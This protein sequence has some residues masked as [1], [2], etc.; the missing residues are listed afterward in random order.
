MPL[1]PWTRRTAL[2]GLLAA[3]PAF[4]QSLTE[5]SDA[6][7]TTAR[8]VQAATYSANRGGGGFIALRHGVII[9]EN[10]ANGSSPATQQ[11]WGPASAGFAV[12]LA[13]AMVRDRMLTLDEP[14][15]FTLPEWSAAP[16]KQRITIRQLL[17][18][19]S[20]LAALSP[21]APSPAWPDVMATPSVFEPGQV[22]QEDPTGLQA[23]AEI[24]RRKLIQAGA[25]GDPATYLQ[26]RALENVGASPV[27]W[28][29][30]A[31]G[32]I[33]LAN[34]ASASL[35]AIA[36]LGEFVRRRGLWRANFQVHAPTLDAGLVGSFPSAGR[37]GFGWRLASGAP[38]VGGE[39]LAAASDL[40]GAGDLPGGI[41]FLANP[42][43]YRLFVVPSHALVVGRTAT[44]ASASPWSDAAFLRLA[45]AGE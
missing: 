40:W 42:A 7:A 34:G 3:P 8:M 32:L 45:L 44:S 39:P 23:F 22:F 26:M 16:N 15:A 18:Q 28:S 1:R 30:Q 33:D 35:R 37:V 21:G 17:Q 14:A 31:D 10:H 20:G 12:V 4:A 27:V 25:P 13:A 41:A 29:R 43:G 11:S 38:L 24:A 19:T 6:S 5:D 2:A 36:R 9:A